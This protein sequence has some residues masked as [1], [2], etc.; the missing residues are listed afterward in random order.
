MQIGLWTTGVLLC[1]CAATVRAQEPSAQSVR[2][3]R[4]ADIESRQRALWTLE[5]EA[6]KRGQNSAKNSTN[7]LAYR[8][9]KEDYEALQIASYSLTDLVAL[10]NF[11]Y[12]D[13][14]KQAAEVKKRAA[15]IRTTLVLP[16]AEKAPKKE[17]EVR[18]LKTAA[19]DLESL[20]Q[21]FAT[22]P[23]FQE[24]TVLDANHTMNARRDLDD[25]V[26]LSE[27]IRKL[28]EDLKK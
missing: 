15:R 6:H 25:I 26:K 12:D 17:P 18:D 14:S 27:L 22:N 5:K 11:S 28:A 9:F 2:E 1:C 16:E 4:R 21:R 19:T 7:N 13:V 23:M 8:Q 3:A 20:V 24:L 10:K